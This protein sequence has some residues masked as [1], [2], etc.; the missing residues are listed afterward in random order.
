MVSRG[1]RA[2]NY[3]AFY[4]M[5]S[6]YESGGYGL[7][8]LDGTL[9]ARS[10]RTGETAQ[11]IASNADLI[12]ASRPPKAEAALL[13]N[14]LATLV[15]GE[16][17]SGS[18]AAMRD[19]TAGYHRMFFE[20][21][22]PLDFLNARLLRPELLRDYKLV[23]VPYPI[24]LT[25]P[26]AAMLERYVRDAG[27]LFAEARPGWVDERGHAQPVIPGFDW[28][29][30]FGVREKSV[31][32]RAEFRV[33]W[34]EAGFAAATFEERWEVL[35]ETARAVAL[36]EDGAPAAYERKHGKG[37][38]L[39]LGAF[40]GQVNETKP[41]AMHPLGEILARWAGLTLPELAASAPVELKQLRGPAG[42]LV[43]FFNH[44]T[45]PARV[46][47][48]ASLDKPAARIRELITDQPFATGAADS[49]AS[50]F[51]T[52]KEPV[53]GLFVET[54]GTRF[55]FRGEIPPQSARIFRLD[56]PSRQ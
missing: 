9:T 50:S 38:A 39:V 13:F 36:F 32:P 52:G 56:Y 41:A 44:G 29:R 3:Y 33:R 1:A 55:L 25:Q 23:I 18:R 8:N 42:W 20:R 28:H 27:H 31:T 46:T 34:G 40:A 53:P 22:L 47:Y 37:A 4:P 2:V 30:M 17:H 26:V 16:Q 45:Q 43:F 10:R 14:P 24:L 6:G 11:K 7:I 21:N 35:D 51:A 15:G 48:A 12:L 5:S 19:A 54:S 49:P